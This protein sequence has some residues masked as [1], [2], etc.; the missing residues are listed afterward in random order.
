MEAEKYLTPCTTHKNV[1][2]D[3][4]AIAC[5]NMAWLRMHQHRHNESCDRALV[6]VEL[7]SKAFS[8]NSLEVYRCCC[9]N[10]CAVDS[11][12]SVCSF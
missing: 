4:Q 10:V 8:P 9:I 7:A 2:V 6:A 12:L 11:N 3:L 1:D 5:S